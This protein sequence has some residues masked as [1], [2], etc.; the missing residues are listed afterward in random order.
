MCIIINVAT[1]SCIILLL[2]TISVYV[3]KQIFIEKKKKL[4]SHISIKCDKLL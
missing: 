1:V 4:N 2:V 3:E